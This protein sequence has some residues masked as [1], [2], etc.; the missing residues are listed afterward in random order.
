MRTYCIAQGSLN[1][2]WRP[3]WEGS[4]RNRGYARITDIWLID[5]A[6]QQKLTTALRSHYT[7]IKNNLKHNE[8]YKLPGGSAGK[9]PTCQH[10][11][12]KRCEFNPQ[13]GKSS[14]RRKWQPTPVFLP[15]EFH[16]QRSLGSY[17]PWGHKESDTIEWLTL[18]HHFQDAPDRC[19][20][21][22]TTSCSFLKWQ[23]S[24]SLIPKWIPLLCFYGLLWW[25]RWLRICLQ[26]RRR[27][28]DPWVGKLPWRGKW[29]P[30]P[31]FLPGEIPWTEEPGRLQS[32]GSQRADTTEQPT[33]WFSNCSVPFWAQNNLSL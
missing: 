9:E 18:S 12:R 30:T 2:L 13:V 10:M 6:V 33:L 25:L 26:C 7:P 22:N 3:D 15:G 21:K 28:F 23:T 17:S 4:P 29:L 19:F 32:M 14:W 8:G 27:G 5:L 11:R 24:A 31:V 1:A 20:A 16:G